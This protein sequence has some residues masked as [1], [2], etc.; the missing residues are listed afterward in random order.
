MSSTD[1]LVL[2][3]LVLGL[4]VRVTQN[5]KEEGE[6]ALIRDQLD[7]CSDGDREQLEN[8][9]REW[10]GLSVRCVPL[11]ACAFLYQ[12]REWGCVVGVS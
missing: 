5:E 2:G 8:Y 10:R 3:L 4:L 9:I 11:N 1:L 7:S 12:M 6:R